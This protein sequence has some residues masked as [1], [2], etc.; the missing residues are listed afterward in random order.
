MGE[1]VGKD[2]LA[3]DPNVV[4]IRAV[5][6]S[7]GRRMPQQANNDDDLRLL[8][9]AAQG[10]DAGAYRALLNVVTPRLRRMIQS[11]RRFLDRDEIEDIVQDVLIS[12]HSVRATYN[13]RRPFL[14]W[15]MAIARNRLADSGRRWARRS[16]NEVLADEVLVTFPDNSANGAPDQRFDTEGLR[17]AMRELPARQRQAIEMLKLRELTLKEAAS[18]SGMTV[19]ALKVAVHRGILTLRK[20]LAKDQ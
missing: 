16:A 7:R 15:L 2:G 20:M 8:M 18:E 9:Q 14:P 4:R 17:S 11:N 6:G 3:S 1:L 5:D 10:G 19:G 12:M 13:A